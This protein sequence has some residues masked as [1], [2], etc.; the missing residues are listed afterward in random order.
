MAARAAMILARWRANSSGCRR[1]GIPG[2]PRAANEGARVEGREVVEHVEGGH[3]QAAA[4]VV[5]LRRA[6]G[7]PGCSPRPASA[8]CG[9][10]RSCSPTRRSRSA[11]VSP[12]R[13]RLVRSK[14]LPLGCSAGSG[15]CVVRPSSSVMR[16][17]RLACGQGRSFR[18]SR[19]VDGRRLVLARR[20]QHDLAVA[21]KVEVL[22]DVQRLREGDQHALVRLEIVQA[23]HR[24]GERGRGH[25][26]AARADPELAQR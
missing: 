10:G 25:A 18:R 17:S 6:Q 13:K 22:G 23:C 7:W 8:G 24:Q 5:R 14:M 3:L 11:T 21:V 4:H 2:R 19:F 1:P 12:P 16:S 15:F 9:T 26:V 20:G